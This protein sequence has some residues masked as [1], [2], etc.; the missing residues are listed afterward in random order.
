MNDDEIT[1]KVAI[2]SG[3]KLYLNYSITRLIM[4]KLT[5]IR[6]C[7]RE[8]NHFIFLGEPMRIK[9]NLSSR[10]GPINDKALNLFKTGALLEGKLHNVYIVI[11]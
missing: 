10:I 11:I 2:C 7:R 5:N 3:L 4:V 8:I 6:F 9:I 1:I